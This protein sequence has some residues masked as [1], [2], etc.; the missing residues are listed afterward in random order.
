[1]YVYRSIGY[2]QISNNQENASDFKIA[3][4]WSAFLTSK[5]STNNALCHGISDTNIPSLSSK[6]YIPQ[7]LIL[8][9]SAPDYDQMLIP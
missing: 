9:N 5:N 3:D 7:S 6:S 4:G 8:S 1:M 2:Q